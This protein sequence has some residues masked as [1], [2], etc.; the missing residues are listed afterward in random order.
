MLLGITSANISISAPEERRKALLR[1][2]I[3]VIDFDVFIQP[4]GKRFAGY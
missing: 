1:Q 4:T 3:A 2:T